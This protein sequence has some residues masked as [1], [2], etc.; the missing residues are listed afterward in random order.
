V[1]EAGERRGLFMS[2]STASRA[3]LEPGDR[4]GVVSPGFAVRKAALRAGIAALEGL[5]FDVAVG[6]HAFDRNGYFA[7]TDRERASDFNR[8]VRDRS[9]RAIWCARGGYGSARIL[10]RIDWPALARDPKPLLGY[11]DATALFAMALRSRGQLCFHAPLVAELSDRTAYD[12]RSLDRLLRG[13]SVTLRVRAASVLAPGRAEGRLVGGNLTTLA[14]LIGTAAAPTFDGS[15]LFL[16]EVGEEAY[17]VDRLLAHLTLAGVF[18]RVRGVLVGS[19]AAPRTR[20]RFPP[21]RPVARVLE[22]LLSRLGVPVVT[23][24]RAGHVPRKVT[25]P[26]GGRARI[27]TRALSIELVPKPVAARRERRR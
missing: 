14:H 26:L 13:E 1:A 8:F 19:M 16:E 25:L 3:I 7:G 27:D 21:D 18:E 15:I 9:V 10:D 17:R 20:R 6:A 12:A 22:E 24:L 2:A 5:G 23:G 4:V 11:S